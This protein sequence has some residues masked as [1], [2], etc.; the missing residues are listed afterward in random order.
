MLIHRYPLTAGTLNTDFGFEGPYAFLT[1]FFT[2]NNKVAVFWLLQMK[3][4]VE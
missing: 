1:H 3:S 2:C 4:A